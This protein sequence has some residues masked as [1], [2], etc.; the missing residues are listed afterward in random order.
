MKIGYLFHG[1]MG[2]TRLG[3]GLSLIS[4]CGVAGGLEGCGVGVEIGFGVG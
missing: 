1:S 2:S 3:V 4:R